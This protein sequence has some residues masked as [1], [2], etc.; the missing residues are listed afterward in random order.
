S[1]FGWPMLTV[2]L[3]LLAPSVLAMLNGGTIKNNG[4][5][6]TES[7]RAI[8]LMQQQLPQSGPGAGSTFVLVFG[9]QTMGV[10]DPAFKQAVLAALQP[11]KDDSSVKSIDTPYDVR[12]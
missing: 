5:Q 11:L 10:Q 8:A 12:A 6:N 4:G 1:R 2:S 3:A 9:S 7:G